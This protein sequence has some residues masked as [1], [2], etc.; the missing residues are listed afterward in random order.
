MLE[1]KAKG[2]QRLPGKCPFAKGD[3]IG[4]GCKGAGVVSMHMSMGGAGAGVAQFSQDGTLSKLG[5][6]T[7]AGAWNQDCCS[8]RQY[9]IKIQD[10]GGWG[11]TFVLVVFLSALLYVGGGVGYNFKVHE[12]LTSA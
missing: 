4:I 10:C 9:A 3:V 5:D 8:G 1:A 2:L 11:W 6:R 7:T 12:Q